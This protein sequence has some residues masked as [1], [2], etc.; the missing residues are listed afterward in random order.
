MTLAH[1]KIIYDRDIARLH[2]EISNYANEELLWKTEGNISNAAGNL[3]LHLIGNLKTYIGKELGHYAY[4][5]NREAEF[6][7]R[8]IPKEDLLQQIEQTRLIVCN[9]LEQLS[10]D[11][12]PQEYPLLVFENKTSVEYML[13]HLSTHLSYHLGQIN[14]HRR[15]LSS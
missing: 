2:T 1:L 6:S 10:P 13:I 7:S 4:T 11:I 14:Y 3:C 12:L 5:R 8:H 15:L 9:T